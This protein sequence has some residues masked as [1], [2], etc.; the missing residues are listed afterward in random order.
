MSKQSVL[1]KI[2]TI[3]GKIQGLWAVLETDYGMH[4][5]TI[6]KELNELEKKIER[7]E[8]KPANKK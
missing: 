3:Q 2:A 5:Q 8:V 7:G 6:T 1:K 4:C